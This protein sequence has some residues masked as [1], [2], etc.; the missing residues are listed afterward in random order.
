VWEQDSQVPRDA[1]PS[2]ATMIADLIVLQRRLRGRVQLTNGD[3][4]FL[5]QL[6]RWFP[7]AF[8][9]SFLPEL[10]SLAFTRRLHPRKERRTHI[11]EP[12][13]KTITGTIGRRH[14]RSAG[15]HRS[16]G[17]HRSS[18]GLRLS[19]ASAGLFFGHRVDTRYLRAVS[20]TFVHQRSTILRGAT[21]SKWGSP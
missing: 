9:K 20:S 13:I 10:K 11:E 18:R 19:P 12:K 2:L 8:F 21:P 3:R 4:L 16:T 6:Y 1:L 7:S 14:R 17:E 5:V 15:E